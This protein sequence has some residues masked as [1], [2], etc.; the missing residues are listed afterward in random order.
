MTKTTRN[1]LPPEGCTCGS[2][3]TVRGTHGK[4]DCPYWS[5]R[6]Y[7]EDNKD[8]VIS[9]TPANNTTP[10]SREGE[11]EKALINLYESAMLHGEAQ[12]NGV[13]PTTK[14]RENTV[15]LAMNE[16]CAWHTQQDEVAERQVIEKNKSFCGCPMCEH[17]SEAYRIAQQRKGEQHE[18]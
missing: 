1:P 14:Q 7:T 2:L 6:V 13:L 12:A 10:S 8:S 11:L 5:D 9:A 17:H 16:V 15:L 18:Q 4:K 3:W